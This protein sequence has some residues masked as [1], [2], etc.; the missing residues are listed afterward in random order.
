MS[1][2]TGTLV[3]DGGFQYVTGPASPGTL[4]LGGRFHI[5]DPRPVNTIKLGGTYVFGKPDPEVFEY[6][7]A[8]WSA[9]ATYVWDGSKWLG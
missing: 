4:L 5:L 7:G 6:V 8:I 2:P 3:L 1:R 9:Q